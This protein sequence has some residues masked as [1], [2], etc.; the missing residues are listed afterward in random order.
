MENY[1]TVLWNEGAGGRQW[2]VSS[3]QLAARYTAY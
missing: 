3:E 1:L 2:A